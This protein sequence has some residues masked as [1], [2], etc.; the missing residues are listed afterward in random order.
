MLILISRRQKRRE[1]ESKSKESANVTLTGLSI[2]TETKFPGENLFEFSI[3]SM[4]VEILAFHS[5]RLLV[6]TMIW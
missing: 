1:V 3:K 5:Q 2:F 4:G 6:R